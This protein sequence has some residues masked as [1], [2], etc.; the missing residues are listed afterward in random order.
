[1]LYRS[2]VSFRFAPLKG[3]CKCTEIEYAGSSQTD[4]G[5]RLNHV[6]CCNYCNKPASASI[7]PSRLLPL[8]ETARF[9]FKQ[10]ENTTVWNFKACTL[11]WSIYT[12]HWLLL[13]Q[14]IRRIVQSTNQKQDSKYDPFSFI[15]SA[16]NCNSWGVSKGWFQELSP[17][18]CWSHILLTN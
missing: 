2:C 17:W 8:Y 1:M 14:A 7:K 6:C 16:Y 5:L 11:L 10:L 13:G 4:K 15:T 18:L 3:D 9:S 12:C